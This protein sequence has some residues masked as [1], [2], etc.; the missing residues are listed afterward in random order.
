MQDEGIFGDIEQ[1]NNPLFYASASGTGAAFPDPGSPSLKSE[2]APPSEGATD[3][4]STALVNSQLGL[5]HKIRK[6]LNSSR[7]RIDVILSERL[8]NSHVIVYLIELRL[9]R[10]DDVVIVKRRYSEFKS[11]R[12]NLI[13]LFPTVIVPPIPEKHTLLTY[14][15][16]SIDNTREVSIIEVRKRYFRNFL[17]DLV[18]DLDPLL[19]NCPLV[20]KFVDP[21]YEMCWENAVNE[22]PVSLI[23]PNPLLANPNNPADQ[24]G[25]Y[26]LLPLVQGY[27]LDSPDNLSNLKKINEDIHKLHNEISVYEL[28]E[29]RA[30]QNS[31][32]QQ[33]TLKLEAFSN[34][35]LDLINFET[36]FHLNIR[37]LRDLEKINSRSVKN[38]K[39]MINILI[40]LGGNLN[41]FS[42]QIHEVNSQENN[43]L[44]VLIEKFGS[45]LDSNFLN[46]E[47]FVHNHAIPDW[48]EP[49]TQ[50]TQYYFS[51]LQL[52]KFYKYKLIQFKLLYKLKFNKIQE[53]A[54][55]SNSPQS[56]KHLKDLNINS[57]S[58]NLAIK[59]I[60]SKQNRAGSL[61]QKKSWY[62]LF[63]GS[64][65]ALFNLPEDNYAFRQQQQQTEDSG[66]TTSE[67]GT[68]EISTDINSHYQFKIR[69]IEKE[70]DKLDQLI[71][72]FNADMVKLTENLEIS[73]T[74]YM[75][76]M[77]RKWLEIMLEFI[78]NGKQLFSENLSNWKDFKSY[79]NESCSI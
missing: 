12:D 35:P 22:P 43:Q 68:N 59:R 62:G 30:L 27:D 24:N 13:R 76:K 52:V 69:H 28:K 74:E 57:P 3:F 18:F 31:Q 71:D 29:S 46:F 37:V 70:L 73:F 77:E 78:R 45:T 20:H 5:S 11:L 66:S 47:H 16:N 36:N 58:I 41:N 79:I 65:T 64:K 34:I 54:N 21:S 55:T 15:V 60:E 39:H 44:S 6:M 40:E 14:L 56:V 72:L 25:L 61:K 48:Q 67:Y 53:Y 23:S 19:K 38:L 7:L 26:L 51:A 4:S 63:G 2:T 1:D 9:D 75:N 8:V 17:R 33:K 49:I 32:E 10:L 50:F 42:L